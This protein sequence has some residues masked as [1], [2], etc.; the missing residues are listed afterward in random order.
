MDMCTFKAMS[1]PS[2]KLLRLEKHIKS[3]QI[4]RTSTLMS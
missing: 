4:P 3:P 2:M 1:T